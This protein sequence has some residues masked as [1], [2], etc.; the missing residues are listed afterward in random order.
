MKIIILGA[1]GFIGSQLVAKL[2]LL[3]IEF[4][5][6]SRS[7]AESIKKESAESAGIENRRS[8]DVIVINLCGAWKNCSRDEMLEANYAYPYEILLKQLNS[9]GTVY[10][11]QASSYFQLYRNYYEV[12][13]DDYSQFKAQFSKKLQDLSASRSNLKVLDGFFPHVIGPGEPNLRLFNQ[14]ALSVVSGS[15]VQ[16]S[17]GN[18]VLP[19]LDVR[20]LCNNIVLKIKVFESLIVP[21]YETWFPNV[22]EIGALKDILPLTLGQDIRLCK[23]GSLPDREN[24]FYDSNV[25]D[26]HYTVDKALRSVRESFLDQVSLLK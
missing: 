5:C 4:Y 9:T 2:N 23:F 13:K 14:L 12:D 19:V 1:G 8:R 22:R 18:T 16:L 26:R 3:N 17:S 15:D 25:L 7:S 21:T 20:D 11:L 10:W 6:L 24:E